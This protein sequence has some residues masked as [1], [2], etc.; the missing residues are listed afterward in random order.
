MTN[1]EVIAKIESDGRFG[2]QQISEEMDDFI[3]ENYT[4]GD[5]EG[6][7]YKVYRKGNDCKYGHYMVNPRT[8]RYRN[9]TFDEFYSGSIVD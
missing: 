6:K 8:M 3:R 7:F 9:S 1:E 4:E 2:I 5:S